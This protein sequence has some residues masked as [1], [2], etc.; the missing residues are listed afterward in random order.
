MELPSNNPTIIAILSA[1]VFFF[2]QWRL[3]VKNSTPITILLTGIG[4]LFGAMGGI[5]F[6]V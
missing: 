4:V 2:I 1:S 6:L 3:N 5:T